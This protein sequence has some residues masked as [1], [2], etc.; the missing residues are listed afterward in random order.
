MIGLREGE[1]LESAIALY[2]FISGSDGS[3]SAQDSALSIS[4]HLVTVRCF[5]HRESTDERPLYTAG[6]GLQLT[7]NG[8]IVTAYHAISDVLEEWERILRDE[9]LTEN[10]AAGWL[11]EF[12]KRYAVVGADGARYPIDPTFV[13]YNKD[14]DTAI[15]KAVMPCESVEAMRFR[16][17]RDRLRPEDEIMLLGHRWGLGFNQLG[18]VTEL[19]EEIALEGKSYQVK[20]VFYTDAYS[21]D[22]FS[23]GVYVTLDGELAGLHVAGTRLDGGKEL[24]HG[25]G[26]Q[27]LNILQVIADAAAGMD[28]LAKSLEER[29]ES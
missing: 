8:F 26:V 19:R 11:T 27:I 1:C 13:A 9:P 6:T 4:D 18:R 17:L 16:I 29:L 3:L 15:I 7:S 10:N 21:R 2:T 25:W 14:F 24:S 12:K 28:E 5:N 23:G 20:D 22:G